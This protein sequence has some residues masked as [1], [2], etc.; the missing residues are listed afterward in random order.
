M[1]SLIAQAAAPSIGVLL[2]QAFSVDT[3]ALSSV[4]PRESLCS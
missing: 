2:I 4:R 3:A 1:L